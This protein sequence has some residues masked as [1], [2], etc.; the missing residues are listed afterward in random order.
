M[1]EAESVSS[2][3]GTA[4]AK[5]RLR[6]VL[7]QR[8]HEMGAPVRATAA[9]ALADRVLN[10]LRHKEPECHCVGAYV[11]RPAEPGTEPLLHALIAGGIRVLVPRVLPDGLL[12]WCDYIG[13]DNLVKG[14][15]GIDE[16]MGPAAGEGALG[17]R[18]NDVDLLVVPALA[19]DEA[20]VRLGQGGGY[21]D[22]L[23]ADLR[24]RPSWPDL[25]P[26]SSQGHQ[27]PEILAL[28]YDDEVYPAGALPTDPHDRPVDLV[29]TP[30]RLIRPGAH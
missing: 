8:R 18:E 17:L 19:V 30:T 9:A 21:Y 16:P 15:L 2:A 27:G 5:A 24:P 25:G 29:A 6:Q 7:R 3:D 12:E 11:S 26:T 20:G 23:L 14:P 4:A 28:V 22:R 1:G 13:P 10:H